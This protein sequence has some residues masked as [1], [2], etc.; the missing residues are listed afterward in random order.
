ML[1]D[2]ILNFSCTYKLLSIPISNKIKT[3]QTFVQNKSDKIWQIKK[4][5]ETLKMK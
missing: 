3:L 4:K 1:N 2:V 5:S